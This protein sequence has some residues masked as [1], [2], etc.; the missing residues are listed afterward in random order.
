LR[1]HPGKRGSKGSLPA[2]LQDFKEIGRFSVGDLLA[3]YTKFIY[4][5]GK[6]WDKV[7]NS[8]PP[9]NR[10][11]LFKTEVEHM[12]L[13]QYSHSID[14][15]GRMIVPARFREKLDGSIYLTQGFDQNLRVL[16]EG[17]F[18]SIYERVTEM[19]STNPTARQL[20][21]LIF[22]TAQQVDIDSSGRILIPKY[23]RDVALLQD[24][25]IIVG[26]G[27]ALEI[28]SPNAWE[29]QNQLLQDADANAERF[30]ALEV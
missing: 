8:G 29:S 30:A 17:I 24:E 2:A 3:N 9:G 23:L 7:V 19:S 5:V 20:R 6:L 22:S 18:I 15:K 14:E 12:F 1:N 13:G 28:W 25:A 27:E 26:V 4:T 21:R 11:S 16:P 10:R